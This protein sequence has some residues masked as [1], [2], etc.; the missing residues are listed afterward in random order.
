MTPHEYLE[1]VLDEQ[2]LQQAEVAALQNTRDEIERVLRGAYGSEP[3]FYYGG[4]YAKDTQIRAAYD[5][6]LVMYFPSIERRPVKDLFEGVHMTLA[7]RGYV[8]TQ[9]TVAL[10]LPYRNGFHIDVVPG[11]AHDY[12]FQYATL[13]KRPTSTL[14]TSLKVHID[15]VR[16][17]GLRPVIRLLKLWRLR[18][19]VP[20][21][22]FA[23]EL[24]SA[25]ALHGR[26]IT[27]YATALTAVL[28]FMVDY[29]T[30]V[31][32]VDPAN[33]N[34]ELELPAGERLAAALL[35]KQALAQPYWSNVVV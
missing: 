19:N 1:Q 27:D 18:N 30:T 26:A 8:V 20:L 25:K 12:T 10:R 11:R 22:T 23:L 35:A 3:R 9:K 34:N 33:S 13:F 29:L 4:S 32:L 14:Q 21:P 15:A 5:L 16:K 28:T 17:S 31:R 7:A 6:D 24:L 2:R